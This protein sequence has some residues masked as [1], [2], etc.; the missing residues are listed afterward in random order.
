MI[1]ALFGIVKHDFDAI[2]EN[3]KIQAREA[4]LVDGSDRS[5]N[6]VDEG[7]FQLLKK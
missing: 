7:V 6:E 4:L 1:K 5:R 3:Y 2:F